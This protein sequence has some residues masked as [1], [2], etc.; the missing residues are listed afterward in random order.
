VPSAGGK[1]AGLDGSR[2]A[3]RVKYDP[4]WGAI[5]GAAGRRL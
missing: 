4:L 2:K 5:G 1:L 3:G